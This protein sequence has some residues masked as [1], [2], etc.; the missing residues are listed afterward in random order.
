MSTYTPPP[1]TKEQINNLVRH[2]ISAFQVADSRMALALRMAHIQGVLEFAI[3]DYRLT[4][5]E[6]LALGVE[7]ENAMNA[8]AEQLAQEK[9]SKGTPQ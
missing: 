6:E 7:A 2:H 4:I 9:A 8:R 1:M 3:R 5:E